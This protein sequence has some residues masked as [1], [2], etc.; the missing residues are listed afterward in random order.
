MRLFGNQN[1]SARIFLDYAASTPILPEVKKE[2]E[3]YQYDYFHNPSAIYK[4]G[5]I[6]RAAITN[7]RKEVARLLHASYKD[8]IFTSGGTE[9]NNQALLGIFEAVR[10]KIKKP[11]FIISS[12]EHS[13]ISE[14]AKEIEKRGGEVAILSVDEYGKVNPEDL[15]RLL[16]NETVLVSVMLANNEIGTVEPISKIARIIKEFR[17]EKNSEYPY[18]H[19]DAS[20]GANYLNLDITSLGV[21]LL[22]LDGSK[23]YGPKSIG[24]LLARQSVLIKPIIFGGGQERGL[25]SGTENV[26]LISGFTKALNIAQS[27]KGIEKNRLD[28]LKR[29]FIEEIK[30]NFPNV[31]INT[32]IEESLPNIVSISIPNQ[33]GEFLA[34]KLDQEGIMIS[35]GSSCGIFKDIGGSITVKSIGKEDLAESTLRFSFGRGTTEKDLKKTLQILKKILFS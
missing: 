34:I 20:Q 22:T 2:M 7:Y 18:F 4:E 24:I 28:K 10:E 27:E 5:T 1:N 33:I 11:H 31:I 14:A 29:C 32:P 19:S 6:L 30:N 13:A 26:A 23:I 9:A 21:D 35:T 12:I 3:K 16:K 17:K 15:K 8:I 25:R